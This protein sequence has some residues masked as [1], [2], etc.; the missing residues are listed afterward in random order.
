MRNRDWTLVFFTS[1]TQMSVG[2]I[3]CFT[4]SSF[5]TGGSGAF[6]G[7]GLSL[8]SPVVLALLL[9][10]A[11]TFISFLHLGKPSNAPNALNNL[12]GSWISR[13]ILALGVYS[14]SL[15]AVLL[16]GWRTGSSEYGPWLLGLG[17]ASGAVLVFMM[18][19][20]YRMPTIP[21]WNG[22]YTCMSFATATFSLGLI[23]FLML[24]FTGLA[25]LDAGAVSA[26][27]VALIL[28]LLVETVSALFNQVQLG[29]MDTGFDGPV[30]DGGT[31]YR[32]FLVR[33]AMLIIAVILLFYLLI[34]VDPPLADVQYIVAFFAFFLV[35]AQE[36]TGR[37]LF[38]SSYF[39]L[40]V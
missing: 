20:I 7:T 34:R 2:I 1:L 25:R 15:V 18:I 21:A 29:K 3:L 13:E 32:V 4:M 17:C 5:L 35:M 8:E 39:R 28:V 27:L 33:M 36:L 9:A 19:R 38:Y 22:W 10:G 30:L 31:F 23:A 16:S 12:R 24:F 40:G 14:A 26:M 6:T 37:L 11:A